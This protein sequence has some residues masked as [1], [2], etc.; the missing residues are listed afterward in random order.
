[1]PEILTAFFTLVTSITYDFPESICKLFDLNHTETLDR[2]SAFLHFGLFQDASNTVTLRTLD[3]I[4]YIVK[5]CLQLPNTDPIKT[6]LIEHLNLNE[7][8]IGDLFNLVISKYPPSTEI[9][10]RISQCI[11]ALA[12]LDMVR[13]AFPTSVILKLLL[14]KFKSHKRIIICF[15]FFPSLDLPWTGSS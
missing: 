12:L 6:A 11:F 9:L 2:F 8:L 10:D 15:R 1:M 5:F 4:E 7:E 3:A 13:T 14:V